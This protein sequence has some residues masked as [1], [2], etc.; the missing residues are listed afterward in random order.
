MMKYNLLFACM[1]FCVLCAQ[2]AAAD[3]ALPQPQKTGGAPVLDAINTRSSAGHKDFPTGELTLQ[4][5]ATLLWAATGTNRDGSKWTVPMAMGRPPYCKI[6]YITRS[7]AWAYDWQ[8]HALVQVSGADH[9]AA[10]ALQDFGKTAP[11]QLVFAFDSK[12]LA[13][14]DKAKAPYAEFGVMLIGAMSQNIYLAAQSLGIGARLVYS[15]DRDATTKALSLGPD[16][17]P[18]CAMYLGK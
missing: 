3:I 15:I 12:E 4:D 13:R 8:K 10:I 11:A 7:G 17:R 18:I 2:C 5:T 14:F 6:Y 9:R 1:F 16:D